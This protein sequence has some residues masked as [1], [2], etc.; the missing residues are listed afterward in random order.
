[1]KIA[2]LGYSGSGKSTLAQKLAKTYCSD[3]LH[4]D[5]VHFLSD[6]KIRSDDEK[7]RIVKEFLDTHESW[8]I[9]GNYSK[10]F[11]GRRMEE[12]DKI[13]L[14]LFNRFACLKRAYRRYRKYKNSTRPDMGEG[15]NEKFDLE[16]IKWILWGGRSS[17]ARNRYKQVISQYTEKVIII[18][19]QKELDNYIKSI[20]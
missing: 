4:L 10:L 16:F 18:K 20:D 17:R 7:E 5:S 19:N 14:L 11:Y 6:W 1:M 15:C 2:I 9:D 8:V 12:A 13:I 3:I